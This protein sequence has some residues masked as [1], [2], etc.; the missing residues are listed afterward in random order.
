VR[1]KPVEVARG[2]TLGR[3]SAWAR[4]RRGTVTNPFDQRVVQALN[5]IAQRRGDT[6]T[7]GVPG[8]R[9]ARAMDICNWPR[10]VQFA[11]TVTDERELCALSFIVRPGGFEVPVRG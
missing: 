7:T 10:V 4:L 5:P 2:K 6:E 9:Y 3:K 1:A 8:E 11:W